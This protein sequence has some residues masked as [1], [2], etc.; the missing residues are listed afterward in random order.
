MGRCAQ[1]Q[2]CVFAAGFNQL[3]T[4][5]RLAT[6]RLAVNVPSV[7]LNTHRFRLACARRFCR[8]RFVARFLPQRRTEN[9]F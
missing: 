6:M 4:H 5:K 8:Y 2:R 3:K 9:S 7:F 1:G